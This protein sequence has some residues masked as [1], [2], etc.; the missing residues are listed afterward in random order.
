LEFSVFPPLLFGERTKLKIQP[1]DG[2]RVVSPSTS[3]PSGLSLQGQ[4][5]INEVEPPEAGVRGNYSIRCSQ[6][7]RRN[8]ALPMRRETLAITV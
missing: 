6:L 5:R 2:L 3:F 7:M 1:F 8:W 4:G